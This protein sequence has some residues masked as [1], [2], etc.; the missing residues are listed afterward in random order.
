MTA[1]PRKKTKSPSVLVQGSFMDVAENELVFIFALD[2]GIVP[3]P[4]WDRPQPKTTSGKPRKASR[5]FRKLWRMWYK[6]RKN[7][8]LRMSRGEVFSP[9]PEKGFVNVRAKARTARKRI[10]RDYLVRKARRV[11]NNE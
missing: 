3:L 7:E 4:R 6:V 11:L 5:K 8:G 2:K 10:V 1:R 9:P